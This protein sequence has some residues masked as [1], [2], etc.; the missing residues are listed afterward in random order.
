M[1]RGRSQSGESTAVALGVALGFMWGLWKWRALCYRRNTLKRLVQ[2]GG[3]VGRLDSSIQD[4]TVLR[5][6][7][8]EVSSMVE[9]HPPFEYEERDAAIRRL[10]ATG[11]R[12]SAER[13]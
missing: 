1:L 9:G 11:G 8:V 12:A 10:S 7:L 5:D 13:S 2:R 4:L 3:I 6:D